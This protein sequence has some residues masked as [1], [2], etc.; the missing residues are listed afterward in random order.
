MY[1]KKSLNNTYRSTSYKHKNLK[2]LL[3]LNNFYNKDFPSWPEVMG[4]YGVNLP[5]MGYDINWIL[6]NRVGIF[7]KNETASFHGANLTLVPYPR[8]KNAIAILLYILPYQIKVF[9]LML[10]FAV[11]N[12]INFVIVRDDA[13]S[14][15]AAVIFKK[16]FK[17]PLIFNYSLP[18]GQGASDSYREGG[19][20]FAELVFYR[21]ED[22]VLKKFVLKIA[23]LILPI[24]DRMADQ[25]GEMG[26]KRKS[27]LSIPLG[28]EPKIFKPKSERRFTRLN[29]SLSEDDFVF[30]YVGSIAQIRGLDLI[31]DA[32]KDV[33]E[34]FKN[35]KLVFVGDGDGTKYLKIKAKRNSVEKDVLFTGQISYFDVPDYLVASDVALSIIKPLPCFDVC[36]PCK[37]F[38]YMLMKKPV[39]ANEEIPEHRDVVNS[40]KCGKLVK[41]DKDSISN[42]MLDMISMKKYHGV[43]FGN[44]GLNGYEWVIRYRTFQK[45]AERID[46]KLSNMV[47]VSPPI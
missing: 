34:R 29:L 5:L 35:A 37:L 11:K 18:F 27:M 24:S 23:D 1:M 2:I 4:I 42:A 44:M 25:L 26:L 39:I 16:L 19:I 10:H 21:M 33:A 3:V 30:I 47:S 40:C 41:Y 28:V 22:Y 46:E 9:C 43:V 7:H 12:K 13:W 15:V 8:T 14:G 36:S 17:I 32:F 31:I 45:M 20:G 38:E 6:P